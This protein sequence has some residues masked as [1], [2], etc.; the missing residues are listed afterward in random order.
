MR[1]RSNRRIWLIAVVTVATARAQAADEPAPVDED[2]L[3]YLGTV[4]DD[5]SDW[6]LFEDHQTEP[7]SEARKA[8]SKPPEDDAKSASKQK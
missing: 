2:F 6:I 5:G 3:E 4:E 7:A 8:P 1:P